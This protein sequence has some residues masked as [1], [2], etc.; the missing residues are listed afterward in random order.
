MLVKEL[1]DSYIVPNGLM[2]SIDEH[3][4]TRHSGSKEERIAATL[5]PKYDN[6]QIWHQKNGMCTLLEEELMLARPPHDDIKDALTAA[7]D[8]AVAPTRNTLRTRRDNVVFDSRFG[9]VAFA[10]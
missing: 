8:I 2:L 6:M 7:I 3:N 9:G 5:E 10:G 1:K 4:P